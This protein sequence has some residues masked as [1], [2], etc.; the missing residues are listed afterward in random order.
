MVVRGPSSKKTENLLSLINVG[1]LTYADE[2]FGIKDSFENFLKKKYKD[3]MKDFLR[4]RKK[5]A[6]A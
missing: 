6:L 1:L 4:D 3:N 5:L 2:K